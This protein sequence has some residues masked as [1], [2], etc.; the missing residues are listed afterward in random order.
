MNLQGRPSR[1]DKDKLH[2]LALEA[3]EQI[4]R[5]LIREAGPERFLEMTSKEKNDEDAQRKN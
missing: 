1:I 4:V 3:A 2:K 5:D